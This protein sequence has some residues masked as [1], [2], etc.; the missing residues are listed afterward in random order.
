LTLDFDGLGIEV[1]GPQAGSSYN[2]HLT[3][4][5]YYP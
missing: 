1:A 2:G 5:I 3:S 4:R